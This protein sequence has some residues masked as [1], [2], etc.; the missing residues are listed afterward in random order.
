MDLSGLAEVV[1]LGGLGRGQRAVAGALERE[2]LLR[3]EDLQAFLND[4]PGTRLTHTD[5]AQRLR[6]MQEEPYTNHPDAELREDCRALY[7]HEKADGTELPSASSKSSWGPR[8]NVAGRPPWLTIGDNGT[9]L[10][11][12]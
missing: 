6:A 3:T 11:R 5:V 8:A 1:V 7:A 12:H 4:L 10:V 2:A 9:R